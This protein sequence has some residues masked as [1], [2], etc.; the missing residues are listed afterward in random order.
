MKRKI[1]DRLEETLYNKKH[2]IPL[3]I[4]WFASP[5]EITFSNSLS[6]FNLSR[7]SSCDEPRC[8]T[9]RYLHCVLH[10]TTRSHPF[11]PPVLYHQHLV[12]TRAQHSHSLFCLPHP[13]YRA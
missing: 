8:G 10:P 6:T 5:H 3:G 7:K 4:W 1:E 13:L 11:P 9:R 12:P 2:W